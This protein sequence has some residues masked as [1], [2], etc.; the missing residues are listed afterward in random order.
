MKLQAKTEEQ[1]SRIKE[2]LDCVSVYVSD[3]ASDGVHIDD[4]ITFDEMAEIVDYLRDPQDKHKDLFEQCW[5]AYNRKGIKSQAYKQWVKLTDEEKNSVMP[6]IKAYVL[7]RELSY[8]KDFERYLRDRVFNDVVVKGNEVLYDPNRSLF[9]DVYSPKGRKIWYD[10]RTQ[11]YWT[12][13]PFYDVPLTDSL[14]V[15]QCARCHTVGQY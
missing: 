6:H 7:S 8:Q 14:S 10:E 15:E 2:I 13:D 5:V 4:W 1:K 11:S 12:D 3:S 9:S